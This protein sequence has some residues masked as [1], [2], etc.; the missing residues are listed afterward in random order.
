MHAIFAHVCQDTAI[1]T[2]QIARHKRECIVKI[3]NLRR[4]G[5][6]QYTFCLQRFS[7]SC[8][9]TIE[10]TVH[11][12]LGSPALSR[13]KSAHARHVTRWQVPG[14]VDNQQQ[15]GCPWQCNSSRR[16][17]EHSLSHMLSLRVLGSAF[18]V[19]PLY[20][21][22]HHRRL[23]AGNRARFLQT[24]QKAIAHPECFTARI[25]APV[26]VLR[27]RTVAASGPNGEVSRSAPRRKNS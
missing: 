22:G 3:Q 8:H 5:F 17:C 12:S 26:S 20:F 10:G 24:S 11:N 27:C 21:Y 25:Y 7:K 9:L 18:E 6:A 13:G 4:Q 16:S 2:F 15:Y 19:Q 14:R 23:I 1:K